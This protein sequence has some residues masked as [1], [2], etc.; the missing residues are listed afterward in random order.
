MPDSLQEITSAVHQSTLRTVHAAWPPRVSGTSLM[1]LTEASLTHL[2]QTLAGFTQIAGLKTACTAGCFF[3]CYL[4]VDVRAH[5]VFLILRWLDENWTPEAV[6]GLLENARRVRALAEQHPSHPAGTGLPGNPD[7]PPAFPEEDP[8]PS[9]RQPCLFLRDGQCSIY[10]V[11]PGACRRYSSASLEACGDLY[12]GLEPSQGLQF[13]LLKE[14]GRAAG[15][16]IHNIFIAKGYDGYSYQLPL[17]IASALED[18]SCWE[19]WLKKEKA[20]PAS[21][22][23]ILPPGFSQSENL[24]RLQAALRAPAAVAPAAPATAPVADA[25]PPADPPPPPSTITPAAPSMTWNQALSST[26]P[27]PGNP[28]QRKPADPA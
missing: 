12:E 3:C 17:A 27:P 2:D 22:E 18:P 7:A 10:S 15:T 24:A 8:P 25:A 9:T 28:V 21:A 1:D 11:R 20:F 16:A 13:P 4:Q 6:G 14:A 23:S 19:R 26:P 5:E